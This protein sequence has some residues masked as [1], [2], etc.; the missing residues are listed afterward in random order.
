LI[1]LADRFDASVGQLVGM[2]AS[3]SGELETT[4]KSM[5]STAEGTNRRAAVVGSAAT[6]ASQRVQTVA[7]AAE[8]LSSSITEISRQGAQSAQV[9]CR[10]V[11]GARRTDNIVRAPS[12]GA[13]PL[14]HVA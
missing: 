13:Q 1:S 5:S 11:D 14:Q 7:A 8:E 4:A 6:E 2:M 9:P 10:A 12:G 3:G